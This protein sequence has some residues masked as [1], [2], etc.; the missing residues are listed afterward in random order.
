[1]AACWTRFRILVVRACREKV[2][3]DKALWTDLLGQR[4][5]LGVHFVGHGDGVTGGGG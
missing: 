2:S 5:G 4:V 3:V 1:M